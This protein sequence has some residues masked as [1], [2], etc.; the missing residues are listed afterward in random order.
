MKSIQD[1]RLGEDRE[2]S[3]EGRF[4]GNLRASFPP[5][6]PAQDSINQQILSEGLRWGQVENGFRQE[7]NG[8]LFPVDLRS[9]DP[10]PR[11]ARG[12][13]L[14]GSDGLDP[15]NQEG[16]AD[17]ERIPDRLFQT[18]KQRPLDLGPHF[19]YAINVITPTGV[20]SK[21]SSPKILRS[22]APEFLLFYLFC[23]W[24]V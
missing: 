21:S 8:D 18:R 12:Q 11:T 9:S 4:A 23:N 16:V 5:P 24:L 19:R 2:G 6:Q 13:H 1:L 15:P 10:T 7:R 20:S 14:L 3:T 17:I 22:E